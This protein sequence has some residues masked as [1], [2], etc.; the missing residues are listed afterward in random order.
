M[1]LAKAQRT[2]RTTHGEKWEFPLRL[3]AFA[4]LRENKAFRPDRHHARSEARVGSLRNFHAKPPSRKGAKKKDFCCCSLRPLRLC[5][6][7]LFLLRFY[8]EIV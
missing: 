6:K 7:L 3:C 2:Q 4:A 5:E 8:R 1:F